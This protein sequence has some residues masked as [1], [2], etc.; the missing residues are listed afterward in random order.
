MATDEQKLEDLK[1]AV[2]TTSTAD[3]E[4]GEVRALDESEEFLRVHDIQHADIKN[5]LEDTPKCKAVVK[6]VD[7]IIMPLL[8]G[9]YVLQYV[10]K[11]CLSYAAVFDLLT[12]LKMTTDEY[13]MLTTIFYL[14]Y[15]VAEY[16][17]SYI[18]QKYSVAKVV[19][20]CVYV[21][22]LYRM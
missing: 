16:P 9:T 20:S 13:A 11:Q 17:W 22:V 7:M 18:G 3:I 15:L 14:G 4:I 2:A 6:R 8:C 10:D 19:A 1:T 5:L 12:D 21:D